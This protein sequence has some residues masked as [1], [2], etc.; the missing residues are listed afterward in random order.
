VV[1][2]SKV[3]VAWAIAL[4]ALLLVAGLGW[5]AWFLGPGLAPITLLALSPAV[6]V[7]MLMLA[8]LVTAKAGASLGGAAG[9]ATFAVV[10]AAGWLL[11]VLRRKRA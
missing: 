7:G 10:A 3:A 2:T 6:G 5:T 9:V 4:G 8:S 11:A 1:P